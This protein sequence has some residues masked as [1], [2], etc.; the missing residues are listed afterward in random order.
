[1]NQ[2][3][4]RKRSNEYRKLN[5]LR[6]Q[7]IKR[8]NFA[9]DRIAKYAHT[10]TEDELQLLQQRV[11]TAASSLADINDRIADIE[12]GVN[13]PESWSGRAS[14]DLLKKQ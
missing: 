12:E 13:R 2:E 4:T 9:E 6:N 5:E 14:V 1:M 7:L 3:N 8:I 10:M 11:N